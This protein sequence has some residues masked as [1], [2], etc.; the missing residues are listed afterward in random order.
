V[1]NLKDIS[2]DFN[3]EDTSYL[4]HSFHPYPAKFPPQLPRHLLAKFAKPGETVL[5]PFCGSGTTLVEARLQGVH[6]VGIDI[7]GLACLLSKVKS[8][9]LS[10]KELQTITQT[11]QAIEEESLLWQMG[12]RRKIQIPQIEGLAHWFQSNVAEELAFVRQVILQIDDDD[13]RDFL[14]IVLSA[15]IVRVSNQESDTRFAAINKNIPDCFTFKAFLERGR[16]FLARIKEFS[17]LAKKNV[18]TRIYNADARDLSFLDSASFDLIITSPPYANTYDYYLYHKFRKRWLDIDVEFAQY[19]EIGSRREFSSLK[20]HPD[21][22]IADLHKCLGEM[23]RVLKPCKPAFIVI[24]D[25][26]IQKKHLRMNAVI[27]DLA[28]QVGFQVRD[29]I[30]SDLSG[31]SKL[32][33]PAFTQRGKKEHLIFL[34]KSND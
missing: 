6:S 21:K 23:A 20:K 29:V 32:F 10:Q 17:E 22:W 30:S 27:A 8:T 33:N 34:E 4:T 12:R 25:S 14:K 24:G 13:I 16:D 3:G 11:F 15:I 2:F 1:R 18:T 31:H 5:D 19:N 9:P 28:P 7:N 26:V